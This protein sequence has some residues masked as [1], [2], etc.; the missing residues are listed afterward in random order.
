MS[1][2]IVRAAFVACLLGSAIALTAPLSPA[3]AAAKP[4]GPTVSAP[5]G[6]LLQPASKLMEANDYAGALVLIKQAQALPDQTP[7]D[8]Y[9]INEFL[10][11]A[12]IKLSDHVNADIAFE[13]MADSPALADVP[14]EERPNTIR[15][16]ALLAT[17]QKHYDKGIKYGL[18]FNALGGAPDTTV[19][20]SMSEAY[21]YTNDFANAEAMAQKVIAATPAGTAPSRSAMEVL[22]GA[23]LKAKKQDAAMATLEQIVT[24]YDDPDEWGQ[25]I[26]VG[27]GTK[28]IKDFEALH[29][30]RLRLVTK[31]TAHSD[32]YTVPASLAL[33][34]GY[35][36]EADAFLNAG[37]G[38][39]ERD[40]KSNALVAEARS[41]AATDRKT[42]DS[43][44]GIAAKAPSGELDLKL[45]ET[46]Y[47]Y[48]RFADAEA[49]ARRALQKGGAK[50]N[51]NEVNM[52]LG[53]ALLM[54]GKTADAIAAFNALS[55]PSPGAAKSQHLWLLYANRKYGAAAAPAPA[56]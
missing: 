11:N 38:T 42:I 41:R 33:S 6:K 54:Q 39:I 52:V 46:Y 7:F 14:A 5:V 36:V 45:A 3:F 47:G 20:T 40:A 31:A 29:I 16:A 35:P 13:A 19:L 21:Y 8:T 17:E 51:P 25:A 10:G 28:G 49:A 18:A 22:F 2:R 26:D 55:N 50:A 34:I 56:H 30:Y 9:K 23:Q 37:A 48:G 1:K 27:L 12:Y 32:D 4:T 43:F 15:I 44:A 24:F 53:Q